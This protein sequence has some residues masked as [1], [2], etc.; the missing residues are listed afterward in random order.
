ME[1]I[2]SFPNLNFSLDKKIRTDGD[3]LIAQYMSK[4]YTC[5]ASDSLLFSLAE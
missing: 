4:V 5:F 2:L 3:A 1:N